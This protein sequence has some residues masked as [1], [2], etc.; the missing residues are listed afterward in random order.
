M[1][2]CP[3]LLLVNSVHALAK[4]KAFNL[5]CQKAELASEGRF[6]LSSGMEVVIVPSVYRLNLNDWAQC[7]PAENLFL[8]ADYLRAFEN[9]SP[10]SIGFHYVILYQ[11][12]VPLAVFYFQVIHLSTDEISLVLQPL[13]QTQDGDCKSPG[14]LAHL[15][16]WLKKMKE[17][18]GFR[19]LVSGNNFISGEYGVGMSKNANPEIVY[20]ALADTVKLIT[21]IDRK[22]AKISAILVKDYFSSAKTIPSDQL[23]KKR[24][25]RFLVEP[26]MIVPLQPEWKSFE[27]YLGAMSKKYRNRA[28]SVLK[29][30]AVLELVELDEKAIIANE[31]ELFRLYKNVHERAKFR[32][33]ELSENY[34]SEMKKSF[35]DSF[36]LTAYKLNGEWIGFRSAFQTEKHLEAHFIGIDY[37]FNQ[38]HCLYQRILYDY[39]LDGILSAVP[40]VYLGRTAAEIKS[41]VGAEAHDL[42]CYIRHRNGLSNQII[43]P[44]I[45][46]LKPSEWIPRNPFKEDNSD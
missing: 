45:D 28:K 13:S 7:V 26:E 42:V 31:K 3:G 6:P 46:Y 35:P 43:R 38:E 8:S 9:T 12:S 32:L 16:E 40:D 23:K 17:E 44:F 11:K 33:A 27:D 25:H 21:R 36:R 37:R 22:P 10:A 18:K 14:L 30:S 29:K 19:L 2:S 24:Y 15:G 5:P 20:N 1:I 41:T 34:F 4:K 39:V